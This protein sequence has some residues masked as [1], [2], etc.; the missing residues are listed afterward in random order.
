MNNKA[1][2]L[3]MHKTNYANSH[4]LCNTE[5]KSCAFDLALL[6]EH[7]M[8]ICKFRDI[9]ACKVYRSAIEYFVGAGLPAMGKKGSVRELAADRDRDDEIEEGEEK[10]MDSN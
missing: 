10:D 9:V 1:K 4:G 6:C 3:G 7:A 5:N 8:D 2:Q